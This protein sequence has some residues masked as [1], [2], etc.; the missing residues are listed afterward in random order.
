MIEAIIFDFDGVIV[1]TETPNYT[2]WKGIFESYGVELE[3]ALWTSS[4]GGGKF[5][6]YKHLEDLS[7]STVD[8]LEL[9]RQV[10]SIFLAA[11]EESPVLPGVLDY[12]ELVTKPLN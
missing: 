5:D 7:G 2:T 4:I 11:I 9:R 6:V 10:R 3:W 8:R 1:D 12:L